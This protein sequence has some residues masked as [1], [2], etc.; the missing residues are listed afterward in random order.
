MNTRTRLGVTQDQIQSAKEVDILDLAGT[1][2]A[3]A[4]DNP[5]QT[6]SEAP[7]PSVAVTIDSMFTVV[8]DGSSA[9]SAILRKG[10]LSSSCSGCRPCPSLR[11]LNN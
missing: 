9:G 7:A 3:T 5:G 4:E 11:Q 10:T 6:V 2:Y 1:T 8:R